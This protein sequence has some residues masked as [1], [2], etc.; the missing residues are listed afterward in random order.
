MD[1]QRMGQQCWRK[2][3]SLLMDS[4]WVEV[5]WGILHIAQRQWDI[6]LWD[7]LEGDI[8]QWEGLERD[9]PRWEG[10]EWDILQWEGLE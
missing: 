8:P 6:P 3:I 1:C 5:F 10:L 2:G 7:G 4:Q 9:I